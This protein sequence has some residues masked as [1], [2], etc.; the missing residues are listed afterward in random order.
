MS[1]SH[2]QTPVQWLAQNMTACRVRIEG[3]RCCVSRDFSFPLVL[4]FFL[5]ES[6]LCVQ[7]YICIMCLCLFLT[8]SINIIIIIHFINITISAFLCLIFILPSIY[9]CCFCKIDGKLPCSIHNIYVIYFAVFLV[10]IS[11]SSPEIRTM[12]KRDE[13]LT[14]LCLPDQSLVYRKKT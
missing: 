5:L 14:Q 3:M 12:K 10:C 8:S 1:D 9:S 2:R 6:I 11:P 13:L 7:K 4:L